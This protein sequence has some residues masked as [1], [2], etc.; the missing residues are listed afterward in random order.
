MRTQSSKS[1]C[2]INILHAQ[3]VP[4]NRHFRTQQKIDNAN[5]LT[6]SN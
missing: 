5:S 2:A 1:L 4:C 3:K 6:T